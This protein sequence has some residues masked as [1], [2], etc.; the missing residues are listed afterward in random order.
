VLK[1]QH[2]SGSFG[3]QQNGLA[4]E[5]N[6]EKLLRAGTGGERNKKS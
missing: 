6:S 2:E 3:G 1:N 5:K 4:P